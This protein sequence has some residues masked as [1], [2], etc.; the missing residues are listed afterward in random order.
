M[1]GTV[2]VHLLKLANVLLTTICMMIDL[3]FAYRSPWKQ[4]NEI[5][6]TRWASG[7]NS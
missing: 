6:D 1:L 5:P 4:P 2:I 3:Y 7:D